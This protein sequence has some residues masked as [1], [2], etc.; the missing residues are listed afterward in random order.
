MLLKRIHRLCLAALFAL[1]IPA[2]CG[3]AGAAAPAE[4]REVF[5]PTP[6]PGVYWAQVRDRTVYVHD[7]AVT[8]AVPFDADALLEELRALPEL[9]T[10]TFTG[11][12]VDAS[13]Q[14]RLRAARPDLTFRCDTELLGRIVPWD[15]GELSLA[16][17]ALTEADLDTLRENLFRLPNLR[18]LDLTD[19]GLAP[20]A[21]CELGE[22]AEGIEVVF[23]VPVYGRVFSSVDAEIDLSDVPVRDGAA[24]LEA[25]L[26]CFSRLEK[27][28]MCNCGVSNED[29]DALNKKYEDVR[30]VWSVRFSIW[31][32]RTDAT[33]FC[34][35]RTYN[36]A[37]LY[38]YHCEQ[39]RYCTDL[40]ALDLGHKEVTDL[41]FLYDLPHL[42]YLILAEDPVRDLTP[43]G[44]LKELRWL[45]IFW[46]RAEDLSPLVNCTALR[47]LNISYVYARGANAFDTLSRMPWLERLWC[48]GSNM[49][50]L[51]REKLR[52]QLPD[53]E[54]FSERAGESTGGSWRYHPHYYE[55][56]DAF[57]MYYMN[58]GE[59]SSAQP[60]SRLPAPG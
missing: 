12:A 55:M 56:R 43:V 19:C 34:C 25:V 23:S 33:N 46:T 9:K 10:V 4:G 50:Y 44:S 31:T 49:T 21:L 51:Q 17:E 57:E 48:C 58:G 29:M 26:P 37:P 52:A 30:F 45:E 47:D 42:Q 2:L 11:G 53:C 13:V 27:V 54:I 14:D 7:R 35:N 32:L 22:A 1:A 15:A 3:C 20:E 24:A 5:G 60:N 18:R 40:I 28:V 41:D 6:T 39:L 38:S 59:D 16:G 36:R 8:L